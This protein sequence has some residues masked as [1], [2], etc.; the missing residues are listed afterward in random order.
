M[1]LSEAAPGGAVVV[2]NRL[3]LPLL[4]SPIRRPETSV[5]DALVASGRLRLISD[6][7]V[8]EG[9]ARLS[10]EFSTLELSQAVRA[11]E[12]YMD[13]ILPYL[14]THED[15]GSLIRD[16]RIDVEALRRE[17]GY[18]WTVARGETELENTT[19]FRNL[20]EVQ[21]LFAGEALRQLEE[22]ITEMGAFLEVLDSAVE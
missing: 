10:S 5:L 18:P 8:R 22:A 17:G 1:V 19:R 13:Q 6:P 12:H 2:E 4:F 14:T 16:R 15:A 21:R 3:L 11:R 20:V 9:I 7:A